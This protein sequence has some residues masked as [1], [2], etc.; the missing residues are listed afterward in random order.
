M[1][2]MLL[3]VTLLGSWIEDVKQPRPDELE[4]ETTIEVLSANITALR[5][6]WKDALKW[7]GDVKAIQEVRLGKEP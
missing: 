2:L 3:I 5:P 1:V 6:R 4:N 7:R